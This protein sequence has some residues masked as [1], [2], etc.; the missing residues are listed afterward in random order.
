MLNTMQLNN[1]KQSYHLP[2]SQQQQQDNGGQQSQQPQFTQSQQSALNWARANP[3]K[4]PKAQMV[5]LKL[6]PELNNG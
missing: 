5:Y 6:T 3:S 4:H 2:T 1:L